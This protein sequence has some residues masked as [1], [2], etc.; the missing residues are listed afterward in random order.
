MQVSDGWEER[1]AR[2]RCR[3][4]QHGEKKRKRKKPRGGKNVFLTEQQNSDL[5]YS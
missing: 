4:K 2:D 5:Q 3:E 1:H